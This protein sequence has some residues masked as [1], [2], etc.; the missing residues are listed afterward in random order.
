MSLS[1]NPILSQKVNWRP[2]KEPTKDMKKI[3]LK[4]IEELDQEKLLETTNKT[5]QFSELLQLVQKADPHIS[6]FVSRFVS[7][8]ESGET[9]YLGT[10]VDRM[11]LLLSKNPEFSEYERTDIKLISKKLNSLYKITDDQIKSSNI[12]TRIIYLFRKSI[13]GKIIGGLL[14]INLTLSGVR[15]SWQNCSK[16]GM[17]PYCDRYKFYTPTQFLAKFRYQADENNESLDFYEDYYRI[18]FRP[19]KNLDQ[20]RKVITD[21]DTDYS[22]FTTTLEPKSQKP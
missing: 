19:R 3:P 5:S 13:F 15:W 6:F 22:Y 20:L 4:T 1:T 11:E 17:L 7:V 14:C 18:W 8:A 2:Y 12:I 10:L 9:I 21:W 16:I